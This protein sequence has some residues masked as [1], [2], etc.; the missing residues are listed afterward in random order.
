MD[1]CEHTVHMVG[2]P[3]EGWRLQRNGGTDVL[4]LR[5]MLAADVEYVHM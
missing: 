2:S 3:T 4:L 5:F 1:I